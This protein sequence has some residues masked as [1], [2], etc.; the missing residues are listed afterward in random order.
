MSFFNKLYRFY[1]SNCGS[2]D[3]KCKYLR[4]RGA[5]IG[6][7]TI[8]NGD[9]ATFG[10]EPYLI[11]VGENCLFAWGVK[12]ITHDGGIRVLNQL[13]RFNGNKADKI[14][15]IV[16]GNNVYVGMSAMIMPGVEIGDNCIIGAHTVVTKNI[17]SNS[18]VVGVPARVISSIDEYYEKHKKY[19]YYTGGMNFQEKKSFY[20]NIEF[21]GLIPKVNNDIK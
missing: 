5:I 14:G 13:G 8:L 18:V 19:V 3:N 16:I 10:G 4:K 7:G 15:K 1:I 9:L 20:E 12:L 17:P 21:E 2:S 11:K 6:E